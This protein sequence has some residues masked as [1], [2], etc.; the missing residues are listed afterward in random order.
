M[1]VI[2]LQCVTYSKL[3]CQ[4]EESILVKVNTIFWEFS[5]IIYYY[6]L[7]INSIMLD[8]TICDIVIIISLGFRHY[9]TFKSE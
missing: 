5:M 8:V 7:L 1:L 9:R 2:L 6:N 4:F 3:K